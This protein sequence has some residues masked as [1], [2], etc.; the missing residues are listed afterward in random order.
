MIINLCIYHGISSVILYYQYYIFPVTA[1]SVYLI[2][3]LY[4]DSGDIKFFIKCFLIF[5]FLQ[6]IIAILQANFNWPVFTLV[7]P[8]LFAS[9][10]NYFGYIF[11]SISEYTYQGS[12]T[13][14]HFNG[15]GS[16]LSL[17]VPFTF[18][19]WHTKRKNW[20]RLLLFVVMFFGMIF[21]F[22][23][24]ALLGSF[25]GIMIYLFFNSKNPNQKLLIVILST[26]IF[27][28]ILFEMIENYFY[29]T[30]NLQSR[31]TV[32]S[33]VIEL[34]LQE[35]EKLI[36][37]YG[38]GHFK[39]ELLIDSRFITNIHNSILQ[40][41]LELGVFGFVLFLLFYIKEISKS[42]KYSRNLMS[43]AV[44]ASLLSFLLHQFFDNSFF[45]VFNGT[46]SFA[47]LAI[48]KYI[49]VNKQI[50]YW[51]YEK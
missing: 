21:T 50:L 33:Y 31:L 20:K 29:R 32:W 37:G 26:L 51:W 5:G 43:Y 34:A 44:L 39:S 12:G 24:G 49:R 42:I 8:Q 13:F 11:K 14:E 45:S 48:L 28:F 36:F 9:E 2:I 16:Y 27:G 15:L 4:S 35:P 1:F 19:F 17:S 22:S 23:R 10:R 6:S 25:F 18:G 7:T 47:F 41:I 40:I 38:Y 3:L 46:I 30:Q